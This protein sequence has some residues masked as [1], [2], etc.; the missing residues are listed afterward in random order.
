MNQANV[1]IEKRRKKIEESNKAIDSLNDTSKIK[2]NLLK[3]FDK[4]DKEDESGDEPVSIEKL[5]KLDQ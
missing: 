4:W 2:E 1:D 3:L 5:K